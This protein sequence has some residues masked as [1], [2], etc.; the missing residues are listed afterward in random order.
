MDFINIKYMKNFNTR[1][2]FSSIIIFII[3]YI[4]LEIELCHEV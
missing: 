3:S 4:K 2:S 1:I